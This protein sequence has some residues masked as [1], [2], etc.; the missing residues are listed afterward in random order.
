MAEKELSSYWAKE[1]LGEG[2]FKKLLLF[3][4]ISHNE[5]FLLRMML[6]STGKSIT[7]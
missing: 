3:M 5:R 1:G 2:M 4:A 6:A 7:V